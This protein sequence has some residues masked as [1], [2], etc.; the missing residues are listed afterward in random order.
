MMETI[1]LKNGDWEAEVVPS[2]AMNVIRLSCQGES[3]LRTPDSPEELEKSAF[4][5]GTPF[6]FPPNITRGDAFTFEGKTYRLP[7]PVRSGPVPLGP[8]GRPRRNQHGL[9]YN[10]VMEI[11]E[12]E[13]YHLRGVF[14]SGT[15]QYPFPFRLI[16]DC[17]LE[18]D[19]LRQQYLIENTGENRMPFLLGLHTTFVAQPEFRVSLKNGWIN[20]DHS[21]IPVSPRPLTEEETAYRDGSSPV[22]KNIHGMF[23]D[24]GR[25]T[26]EIG[27]YAYRLSE[28]F[29]TWVL[30]NKGG[31]DGFISLEP[32]SGAVNG[33]N[34]EGQYSVLD[35][36]KAEL[37]ETKI[38]LK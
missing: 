10:A 31:N 21:P 12:R 13:K 35:P 36:G 14:H 38:T 9:L 20:E 18:A 23:T 34:M 5:Y 19:G 17:L 7:Y 2:Y 11:T 6:L 25:H 8:G 29:T 28:N 24:D 33:L 1:L 32:Q 4:V 16:V 15:E 30:W 37:F 26:A 22:G 3:I 27:R